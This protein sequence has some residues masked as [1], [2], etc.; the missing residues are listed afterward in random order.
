VGILK[1][2]SEVLAERHVMVSKILDSLIKNVGSKYTKVIG[3]PRCLNFLYTDYS[4]LYRIMQQKIVMPG[5]M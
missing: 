3:H 4:L 2:A 1:G 5:R